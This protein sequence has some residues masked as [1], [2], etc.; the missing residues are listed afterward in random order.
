MNDLIDIPSTDVV[1][2]CVKIRMYIN[3]FTLNA[4]DCSITVE[5]YDA[6][7]RIV[8]VV[9]VYITPEEYLLWGH[10]DNYIINLVLSKIGVPLT[11]GGGGDPAPEEPAV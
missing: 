5:K 10:D 11:V 6:S 8:D 3:N 7:L 1:R 4:T 2:A 9:Q